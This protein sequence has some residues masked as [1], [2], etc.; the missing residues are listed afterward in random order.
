MKRMVYRLLDLALAVA[1]S[2]A[3]ASISQVRA[4]EWPN[5][6]DSDTL[7]PGAKLD[8]PQWPNV[9]ADELAK[10][11]A[12]L[13]ATAPA[14][15]A[16]AVAAPAVAAAPAAPTPFAGLLKSADD[17][18][19]GSL[20]GPSAPRAPLTFDQRFQSP[21]TFEVG[22]RYWY[23]IGQNR[24]AFT[25]NTFP[26]GNP[27][28]TL[29]WDRM[30]GHSGEGFFRID[31]G[32]SH[33]YVK[34]LVGGGI[35]R[36]GDL[37]DLDFLVGQLNFSNTTSAVSGNNLAY[38]IVDLGYSFDVPSA[39]VR[40]GAFVG[41]HY[42]HERMTAYGVLCNA[43]LNG[44]CGPA[45]AI[46]VPFSTAVDVFDT[47]W[48]AMRVGGEARYEL[49]ERWTLSGEVAFVPYA[50]MSNDDSHLLRA[51]LG[52]VPNI[53]THGWRGI[54]GEAEALIN[55]KVLPHF[56]IGAGFRYWGIFTNSGSVD[57]GPTFSPD[58]PLTKFSTQRY[59]LLL[60]AKATF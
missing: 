38:G 23:S 10:I 5:I 18:V 32:P 50:W 34:G 54:G 11:D 21:F 31:H 51:D 59:G 43:D 46:V 27:T 3:I 41:Y 53:I 17:L 2:L 37:D 4:A 47:T 7:W 6:R 30:Q 24:F 49:G 28:S 42:W 25:N 52:P 40:Y 1:L 36:G 26:Y 60:Q 15:A 22:T 39:G 56:D 12:S 16:P 35:L 57:F 55:Y 33:L 19:T 13:H 45:G 9:S 29:D 14:P 8:N 44:F 58:Y 20:G 48:N